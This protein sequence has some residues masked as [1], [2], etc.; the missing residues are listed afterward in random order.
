[1]VL[2]LLE[3][4]LEVKQEEE[5]WAEDDEEDQSGPPLRV[6]WVPLRNFKRLVLGHSTLY[7]VGTRTKRRVSSSSTRKS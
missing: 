5:E 6:I 2:E 4:V 7:R 1:M 3:V